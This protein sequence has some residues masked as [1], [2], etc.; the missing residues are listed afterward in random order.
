MLEL[1]TTLVVENATALIPGAVIGRSLTKAVQLGRAGEAAAAIVK[2]TERIP[3][4]TGTAAYRVPDI[5][6]HSMKVIGDVKNVHSLS[7]TNQLRDFAAYASQHGYT[8]EL[9]V[10]ATV[11]LS[12]PLQQ[13][14]SQGH[15]ALRFLP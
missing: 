5:L 14:I 4:I 10:P 2:N 6:D 3:S 1:A 15:I 9:W 11:Q 13:A 8:F 12:G 7:Y